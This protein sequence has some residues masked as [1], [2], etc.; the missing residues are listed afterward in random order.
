MDNRERL[1]YLTSM[2]IARGSRLLSG[3]LGFLLTFRRKR[4]LSHH[5]WL[6][7]KPAM[8]P[9][10]AEQLPKQQ[11]AFQRKIGEGTARGTYASNQRRKNECHRY[12]V[13]GSLITGHAMQLK[14]IEGAYRF[15][16]P[17][18]SL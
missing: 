11:K 18:T 13:R 1:I 6:L 7:L 9:N 17:Q 4:Q 8:P 5:C 15:R 3:V 16:K 10:S 2:E 14:G 12:A